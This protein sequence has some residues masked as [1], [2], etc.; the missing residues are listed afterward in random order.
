MALSSIGV[1]GVEGGE[2][3]GLG[4]GE[5]AA[6]L[7]PPI[8][9]SLAPSKELRAGGVDVDYKGGASCKRADVRVCGGSEGKLGR[10]LFSV[11]LLIV[12]IV[13]VVLVVVLRVSLSLLAFAS[14]C[15]LGQKGEEC[16]VLL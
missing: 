5:G 10:L 2:K 4:R 12:V 7:G 9:Y 16:L 11:L 3:K 6:P 13:V 1:V 15:F 8:R 14:F